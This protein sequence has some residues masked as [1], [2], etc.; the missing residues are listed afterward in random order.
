MGTRVALSFSGGKDSCF[1]LHKLQE[2]NI[3]IACLF[4]TIWKQNQKTVA[5]EEERTR[6]IEQG[7]SLNIPVHF[8]ETDFDD[9]REDFV[10]NLQKLKNRYVLDGVA[11]GDIY[12][13]GHRKW[14]EGV[15]K[16]V[17]LE[18][19]YPLWTKQ[20]NALRLLQEFVDTGFRAEVI[21]IDQEKLPKDWLG[22]ELDN[23]FITDIKQKDVCPMGESG[24]YHTAVYDGPGFSYAILR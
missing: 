17:D 18:A 1:A 6:I 7:E 8:I 12:L 14:G 4:T 16:D 2:K 20:D 9:Y 5:H 11:F 23:T 22:R 19:V 15:A 13:E 21:K 24:E 10:R 3:E